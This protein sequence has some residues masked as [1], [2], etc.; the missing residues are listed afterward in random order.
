MFS[1]ETVIP[2]SV[3]VKKHYEHFL[4]QAF[5]LMRNK[6]YHEATDNEVS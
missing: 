1:Q 4:F 5:K 3:C 6:N 2:T